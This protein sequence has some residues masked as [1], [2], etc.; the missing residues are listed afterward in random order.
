M[1]FSGARFSNHG[2]VLRIHSNSCKKKACNKEMNRGS[3]ENTF[4]SLTYWDIKCI[5][6]WVVCLEID[7]LLNI[8]VYL[9]HTNNKH[10]LNSHR[11][12]VF[13]SLPSGARS[14]DWPP[15]PC[16]Y[17]WLLSQ[18]ITEEDSYNCITS[19]IFPFRK[20]YPYIKKT[21]NST[22]FTTQIYSVYHMFYYS[23]K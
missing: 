23:I 1:V 18:P 6:L 12:P 2:I 21:L 14:P 10:N 3:T 13:H 20:F 4:S 5:T 16:K 15:T 11:W 8:T 9:N 19:H 22:R 17:D 7:L